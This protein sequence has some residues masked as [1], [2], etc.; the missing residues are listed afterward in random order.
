MAK[1][2]GGKP[3]APVKSRSGDS[4]PNGKAYKKFIKVLVLDE[5]R[6]KHKQVRIPNPNNK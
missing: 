2:K 6:G 5:T 3:A 1:G 4:R